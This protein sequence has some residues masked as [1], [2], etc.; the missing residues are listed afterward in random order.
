MTTYKNPKGETIIT[1][2]Y[3]YCIYDTNGILVRSANTAKWGYQAEKW[4]DNDI[5]AGYYD[6]FR[7]VTND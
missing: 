4:I 7:K 2:G 1:T 3:V 6:N 5:A